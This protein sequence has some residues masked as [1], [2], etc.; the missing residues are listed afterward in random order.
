[1][2]FP[3]P[4]CRDSRECFARNRLDDC[5]ILKSTYSREGACTFCKPDKEITNGRRYPHDEKKVKT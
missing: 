2:I 5:T 3:F 4:K 1:M